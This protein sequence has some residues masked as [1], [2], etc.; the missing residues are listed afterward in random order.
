MTNDE[1][2][3]ALQTSHRPTIFA[4]MINS[5][6]PGATFRMME[7]SD[8]LFGTLL[9]DE[10]FVD[11]LK[12]AKEKGVKVQFITETP[13]PNDIRKAFL[14]KEDILLNHLCGVYAY[15]GVK[16]VAK[17]LSLSSTRRDGEPLRDYEANDLA[18][19][20]VKDVLGRRRYML[21]AKGLVSRLFRRNVGSIRGENN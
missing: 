1:V 12:R 14:P 18:R 17:Y 6:E 16:H 4:A 5:A 7:N 3:A 15:G 13:S 9:K 10:G 20:F 19:G 21:R 2:Y 11:A 8:Y